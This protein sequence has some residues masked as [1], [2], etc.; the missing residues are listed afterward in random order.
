MKTKLFLMWLLILAVV[1]VC[2]AEEG[3]AS[4]E[5]SAGKVPII[6]LDGP[7]T[8]V[9]NPLAL[10]GE[11]STV[12]RDL[13]A[14]IDKAAE[15]DEVVGM[16]LKVGRPS[17]G[18]AQVTEIRDHLMKFRES[19]KPL[20]TWFDAATPGGYLLASTGT[21]VVMPEVGMLMTPGISIQMY[22][23]K[24][25]LAK[26]GAEAEVV[27]SGK[28]KTA[29]EPF[30]H[31]TMS[32]GNRIQLGEILDDIAEAI[33]EDVAE[34][35]GMD[36]GDV[37]D[38]LWTGPLES[39]WALDKGLI[40]D[41]AYY[42]D[43]LDQYAEENGIEYDD[44]YRAKPKKEKESINLFTLF[45]NMNAD[46]DKKS[47]GK[48]RIALV[49]ALGAIIDGRAD[50]NP[51]QQG[52]QIASED[53]LDLLDDVMDEGDTKAIVLRVDSP[54]GSAIASDR[55]WNRLEQIQAQGVPVVVSMGSVAASGGYYISMGADKI[56]AEPTTLTGSIGV[57]GGKFSFGGTY[58]KIGVSKQMLSVG[59]NAT[60]WDEAEPWD[61]NEREIMNHMIDT[62][63]DTFTRKV[64][65]GRGM[66]QD[67]V[68]E[69]GQGRVWSGIDAKDNG[70]IDELG[71]T[72]E[73]IAI[74]RDMIGNPDISI[75]QYP[76]EKTFF[77]LLEEVMGGDVSAGA[78]V[79]N[80]LMT[81]DMVQTLQAVLPPEQVQTLMDAMT[82]MKDEPAILTWNPINFN[83][84]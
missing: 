39:Q 65:D 28:F 63:Y 43:F 57:V 24:D 62:T 74:A 67:R 22:Y 51:F 4:E 1:P 78:I 69:L 25:L 41:I 64:A 21:Q 61:E 34:G 48:E 10:F 17:V 19:G 46:S 55:I 27:N 56:V 32:E 38:V 8:E 33:V 9:S 6:V 2:A 75:V 11:Q 37:R 12:L 30:T 81:P 44:E 18:L 52:E 7:I 35:R 3:S 70:L 49:Y 45:S 83:F 80:A 31:N 47:D 76:R 14:T 40:T 16:I 71:G 59:Q 15:D 42:Q 73:A 26:V 58:E 82:L 60:I 23:F 79:P 13:T 5:E 77:E 36:M 29:M 53:F 84:R 66:T 68:K 50:E 54:G 72:E 20:I